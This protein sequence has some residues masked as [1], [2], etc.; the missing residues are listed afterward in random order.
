MPTLRIIPGYNYVDCT[1]EELNLYS[2]SIINKAVIKESIKLI[3]VELSKED[4][5]EAKKAMELNEK[6]NKACATI[7]KQNR[8]ILEQGK[9]NN[10]Q[11]GMIKEQGDLIKDLMKEV[12]KLKKKKPEKVEKKDK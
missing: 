10:D 3:D 8:Q 12:E 11:I 2:Q 7:D 6:L 9:N 4:S 5:E 1:K